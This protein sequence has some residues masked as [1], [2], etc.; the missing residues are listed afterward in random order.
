LILVIGIMGEGKQGKYDCKTQARR[1]VICRLMRRV[2]ILPERNWMK[3]RTIVV[4]NEAPYLPFPDSVRPPLRPTW[5][6]PALIQDAVQA[7]VRGGASRAI[8]DRTRTD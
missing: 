5:I 4:A 6:S 1:D 8:D 7:L 2:K 3:V